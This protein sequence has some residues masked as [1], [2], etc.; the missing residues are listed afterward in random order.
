MASRNKP[1]EQF[2][3]FIL[4]KKL[5]ADALSELWRAA[6]ID[7]GSLGATL[8]LRRFTGGNREALSAAA[9]AARQILPSLSGTSFVRGQIVDAVDGVPFIAYEYAGG[10]SLRHIVD[11]AR[12]GTGATPNP[13]PI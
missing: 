2:G 11:R 8:A 6:R 4:F 1:Y 12:G 7:N 13:I 5:E 3:N 10:R 9:W